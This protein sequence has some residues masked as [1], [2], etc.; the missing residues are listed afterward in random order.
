MRGR[1]LLIATSRY[2]DKRLPALSSTVIDVAGLQQV[3]ADPR[4]GD[5][6]VTACVD[7]PWREWLPRIEGFFSQARRDEQLLLYICGHAVKDSEGR[8]Y[9]AASDTSLS[10]LL[11]TGVPASFIHEA[12]S[13]S[14]S[15]RVVMILDTCFGRAFVDAGAV[16]PGEHF[17]AGAGRVVITAS[18]A[19][20]YVLAGE[21]PDTDW[22]PS[23]LSRHIIH[24][25]R[26]GEADIDGD[27]QVTSLDLIKYMETR[28]PAE[29]ELQRPRRWV[30]GLEGDLVVASN[31]APRAG[32]L[33]L[34][35]TKLMEDSL[36]EIRLMAVPL[37]ERLLADPSPPTALAARQALQRLQQDVSAAV[38]GAAASVLQKAMPPDAPVAP[39]AGSSGREQH[40]QPAPP[41]P[42]MQRYR[43]LIALLAVAG[44]AYW[45]LRQ[46]A[47]LAPVQAA[48]IT[49]PGVPAPPAVPAAPLVSRHV[50]GETFV[51]CVGPFCPEMV[52]IPPGR[53]LMG[54][55]NYEQDRR[56][57]EG[58]VHEV[59][60][61]YAFAASK[62]PVT[63]GQWR[64]FL[65]ATG[66]SAS[67]GCFGWN[68][69]TRKWEPRPEYSWLNPG[70]AQEDSHPVVCVSWN[71]AEDYASWLSQKTGHRY[72]L[73]SEAEYE[74]IN[75]AGS[76]GPYFWG[77]TE[78]GQ[79][80]YAN[81]ADATVKARI[82]GWSWP[83]VDCSDGYVFTSSVGSFKPNG[84]G[85]YDTTGNV[86]S[87]TQD[88][89]HDSYSGAP[90]DGSAWTTGNCARR[91]GRGSA[92]SAGRG[93]LRAARRD[94]GSAAYAAGNQGLRVA[95]SE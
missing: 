7:A 89:Y 17:S 12:S 40:A 58:P 8:L 13:A 67:S 63:R 2:T 69:S 1:A 65:A 38:T 59:N 91:V 28:V 22:Q 73:L 35:I 24:G 27:A 47:S 64:A 90:T 80:R 62:Y 18:N 37:L 70:F 42:L 25:L 3:L 11:S 51:D 71:E 68:L 84:F 6:E 26:T 19:Y 76:N 72:R 48:F 15:R 46:P 81:G 30:F 45:Y 56:D 49:S 57:N 14:P 43:A 55:P 60:I 92:W 23:L 34:V 94:W 33:P 77:N 50:V 44:G 10:L 83:T 78:V 32:G 85:L 21:P 4:I 20:Q 86:W 88:C 79:C 74:Y 31:P 16:N 29:T 95:R 36:E 53:F 41:A 75:R 82:P 9:F 39:P 54:S 66:R 87:L 61:G 52:M 93:E 5:F